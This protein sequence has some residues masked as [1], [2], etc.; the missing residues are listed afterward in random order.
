MSYVFD[1]SSILE[2]LSR[3]VVRVLSGQYTVELARFELNNILW[4]RRTLLKD[5]GDEE[6]TRLA[7]VLKR[8]L[9]LMNVVN[10]RCHEEAVL[11]VAW[12]LNLTFYDASYVYVAREKG[13]PL[14]TEDRKLKL[15]ADGYV[16]VLSLDDL[17]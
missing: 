10:I 4:K 8:V 7:R 2:A 17:L 15:R 1:S 5:I 3:G 6:L 9:D 12:R 14:V 13:L 16:E 11:D